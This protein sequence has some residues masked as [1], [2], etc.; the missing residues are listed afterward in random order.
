MSVSVCGYFGASVD[1]K[2]G[3]NRFEQLPDSQRSEFS[4]YEGVR[5]KQSHEIGKLMDEWFKQRPTAFPRDC[6]LLG[7]GQQEGKVSEDGV[8]RRAG[9]GRLA[10]A[11]KRVDFGHLRR[12]PFC[13][14]KNFG[15]GAPR[16]SFL[17][18]FAH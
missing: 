11:Q 7:K 1:P 10:Y 13:G 5:V 14:A 2:Q 4:R 17:L 16:L 6:A 15:S 12:L 9:Q 18:L 3:F 8:E